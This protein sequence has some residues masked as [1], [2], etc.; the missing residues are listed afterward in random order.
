MA[1]VTA[2]YDVVW[3]VLTEAA[4]WDDRDFTR[5]WLEINAQRVDEAHFT[6]VDVY[7]YQLHPAQ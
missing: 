5:D 6:R 3:L 2:G 4:M 1:S 7:R